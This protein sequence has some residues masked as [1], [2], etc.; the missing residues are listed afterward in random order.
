MTNRGLLLFVDVYPSLLSHMKSEGDVFD[1]PLNCYDAQSEID[2][3]IL[4]HDHFPPVVISLRKEVTGED[5]HWRR[6]ECRSF[7]GPY[8]E[9]ILPGE[10][11]VQTAFY[12]RQDGL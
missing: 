3:G 4:G 10:E 1:V 12:I 5:Q 6:H 7:Q 8:K 2:P 9:I 11:K